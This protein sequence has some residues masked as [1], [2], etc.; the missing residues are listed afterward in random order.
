ME[1]GDLDICLNV[2]NIWNSIE[3]YQKLGFE[4]QKGITED[5]WCVLKNPVVTLGLY[6]GHIDENMLNFRCNDVFNVASDL[7][8]RGLEFEVAPKTEQDGSQVAIMR[9][10]DGNLIAF[11][12]MKSDVLH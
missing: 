6:S 11:N 5:G 1:L 9:D 10:P 2:K 12:S 7:Q 3:F 4:V 8:K